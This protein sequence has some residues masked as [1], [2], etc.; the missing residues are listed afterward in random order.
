LDSIESQLTTF[1]DSS[2]DPERGILLEILGFDELEVL[3]RLPQSNEQNP[4]YKHA[5]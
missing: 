1:E 2:S 4:R 5:L 3:E